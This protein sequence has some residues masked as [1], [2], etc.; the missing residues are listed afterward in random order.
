[1]RDLELH[2]NYMVDLAKTLLIEQ[3]GE[4]YPLC[5]YVKDNESLIPFSKFDGDE[6]PLSSDLIDD[7]IKSMQP[8]LD[9]NEIISY[10]I[11]F[12]CRSR[13]NEESEI[14]D[15]IAIDY[16]SNSKPFTTYFYPYIINNGEVILQ[17]PWGVIK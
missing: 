5:S 13:R 9:K 10:A 14:L 15:A 17:E 8:K 6:Q 3:N 16:R 12:D 7:Y 2:I 1:M 11:A 4:F